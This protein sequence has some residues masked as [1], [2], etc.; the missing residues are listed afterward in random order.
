MGLQLAKV[1]IKLGSSKFYPNFVLAWKCCVI[2]LKQNDK[3]QATFSTRGNQLQVKKS[4]IKKLATILAKSTCKFAKYNKTIIKIILI[5]LS[6]IV[7]LKF[8]KALGW[9]RVGK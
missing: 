4:K 5:L 7:V 1:G 8:R 2:V 9:H 6:Y 3:I